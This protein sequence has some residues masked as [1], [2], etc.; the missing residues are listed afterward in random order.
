MK[1]KN[2]D[3]IFWLN[4]KHIEEGLD[5]ENLQEITTKYNSNHRKHIYELIEE[6][7]KKVQ[8]N[9]CRW[10]IRNQ[11]MDSRTMSAHEFRTRLQFKQCDVILTKEP[12]LLTK[13]MSSFVAENLQ[14]SFKL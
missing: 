9:S 11:S 14:T 12:S 13:I 1:W 2:N 4:A 8:Q 3:G 5:H 10:K 7:K 6:P